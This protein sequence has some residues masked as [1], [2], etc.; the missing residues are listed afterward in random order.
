VLGKFP[1]KNPNFSIFSLGV[2][3]ISSGWVKKYPNQRRV[4]ILFTAG[5]KYTVVGSGQ[6]PSLITLQKNNI[7]FSHKILFLND[8]MKRGQG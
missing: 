7:L 5:Q 2:K 6:G 3:K 1:L 4:G 8:L